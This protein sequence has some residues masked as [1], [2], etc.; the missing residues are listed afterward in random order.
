MDSQ[1]HWDKI[2]TDKAQTAVSWYGPH[3]SSI[4]TASSNKAARITHLLMSC[5]TQVLATTTRLYDGSKK[6]TRSTHPA[7]PFLHPTR[8]GTGCV[9]I[10]GTLTCCAE[11]SCRNCSDPNGQTVY[12]ANHFRRGESA[13]TV[14]PRRTTCFWP[15]IALAGSIEKAQFGTQFFIPTCDGPRPIQSSDVFLPTWRRMDLFQ[16]PIR[17][18]LSALVFAGRFDG[19]EFNSQAAKSPVPWLSESL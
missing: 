17:C 8:S 19:R 11:S 4:A 12:G 9:P 13:S 16:V 3:H 6:L 1:S 18:C 2:Y 7:C 10:P 15:G 14:P 5:S